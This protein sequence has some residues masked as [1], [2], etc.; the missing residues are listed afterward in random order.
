MKE[1]FWYRWN[2]AQHLKWN[3][4]YMLGRPYIWAGESLFI[5][6]LLY[7]VKL[8]WEMFLY[9]FFNK[10]LNGVNPK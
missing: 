8:S 10:K 9:V 3:Y 6:L 5:L 1:T 4:D 2:V 7:R